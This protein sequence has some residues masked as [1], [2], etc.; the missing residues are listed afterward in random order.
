MSSADQQLQ[1][2]IANLPEKTGRS[3]EEWMG[4]LEPHRGSKHGELM[5]VLKKE[6][7]M[8]HGYANLVVHTFRK[9]GVEAVVGSTSATPRPGGATDGGASNALVDAQYEGKES[10]RPIYDAVLAMVSDFGDEL[11]VA[12][13]KSYVS[14]RRRIQFALVQPSTKTRV[15]LGIKLPGR[16][17][18]GR[19][20]AAGSWNSMV[21]HRVRLSDADGVDDDVRGWLRDAW[22]AAG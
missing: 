9:G 2:M 1:T 4:V 20:E 16:D 11:E 3:L 22:D 12:P 15:D 17:P 18:E 19:L 6:H 13:K 7:G 21:T 5:K 10:L 8:S 14:L